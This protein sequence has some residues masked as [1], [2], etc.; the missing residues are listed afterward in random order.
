MRAFDY[1]ITLF[2][3]VYALA[4]THLLT[5][6]AELV[7]ERSRVRFSWV[8][9]A[10]MSVGIFEILAWWIGMWDMRALPSWSVPMIAFLFVMATLIYLQVR[11]TC[12]NI[13]PDGEI[14]LR[15]FHRNNGREYI[16][17]FALVALLT[18]AVNVLFGEMTS[19]REMILQNLA[20]VPMFVVAT[21]AA[22]SF[23]PW[24]QAWSAAAQVALWIFYFATLQGS[25]T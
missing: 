7:R 18:V 16:A 4:T 21:T 15:Q 13:P 2:A 3:F 9:A 25:L 1:V 8:H 14:D 19:V 5:T 23:R 24:V 10:W 12:P 22:I 17:A 20:V 11:L 6:V